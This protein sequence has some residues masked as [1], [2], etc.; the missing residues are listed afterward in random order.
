MR[1]LISNVLQRIFSQYFRHHFVFLR[2]NNGLPRGRTILNFPRQYS[3]ASNGKR[4]AIKGRLIGVGLT[5]RPRPFTLEAYP[6]QQV[7]KGIIQ[8]QFPVKRPHRKARRPFTMVTRTVHLHVRCRRRSIALARNDNRTI[9]RTYI[10][11]IHRRRLICRRLRVIILVTI[12]LRT[13]RSF[14]CLAIRACMRVTFLT[15]LLRRLLMVPLATTRR[16]DGSVGTFSFMVL[17]SGIRCLFLN[18]LRRLLT[19]RVE[20]DFS[21]ANVRRA[22]MVVGLYHYAR[23]KA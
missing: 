17:R 19:K 1:G 14:T 21:Y 20:V 5:S 4:L 12:R 7:R 16:Q 23:H 10:V 18:V 3:N 6:L 15:R 2:R 9:L 8:H 13:K 11:L 22:G